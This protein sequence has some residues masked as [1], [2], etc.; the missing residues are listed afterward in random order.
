MNMRDDIPGAVDGPKVQPSAG[1]AGGREPLP[2]A[3]RWTPWTAGRRGGTGVRGRACVWVRVGLWVWIWGFAVTAVAGSWRWSNPWPHGNNIVDLA[4]RGGRYVQVTDHGGIYASTNRLVWERLES[5]TLQDLRGLALLGDRWLVTGAEGTALYSDD[6]VSFHAARLEPP[7]TAWLEGVAASSD[8]AIAVA[9]GDEGTIYRTTDGTN[10]SRVE[11]TPLAAWLSGVAYGG[12]RFVAVGEGGVVASSADGMTW[13][14]ASSPTSAY[15]TRVAYGDGRFLAV[16]DGGEILESTDGLRWR[17]ERQIGLTND[18]LVAAL[19]PGRAVVAGTDALWLRE[20]TGRWL[21]QL[22]DQAIPVPAPEWTYAA[23]VWDGDRWLL[24]GRTGVAVEGVLTN[25]PPLNNV[26]L[27]PRLDDS[28]RG[29]LWAAERIGDTYLAVGERAIVLS[30]LSGAEWRQEIAQTND[31]QTL[32]Y[33]VG[34]SD[35]MALVV[36][37]GGGMVRSAVGYAEVTVTNSLD[38]GGRTHHLVTTNR[39]PLLG[40]EWEAVGGGLTTATLQGVGWNGVEYLVTGENGTLLRSPN[41]RDWTL[42][43]LGTE[44]L[45]SSVAWTG[46]R[47]VASGVSGDRFNL[48]VSEDADRWTALD[49]G[50]TN[51]IYRVRSWPGRVVAVG[52]QGV[53]L[54]SDDGVRW[55]RRESGTTAFLTDV[56]RVGDAYYV[57]GTEGTLRRSLDLVTWTPLSPPTG[58]SILGLASRG[59]QLVAVGA[60]GIILRGVVEPGAEPVAITAFAHRR[61]RVPPVDLLLLEGTPEAGFHLESSEALNGWEIGEAQA[62]DAD[63][64][65]FEAR[66]AATG[67]RFYRTATEDGGR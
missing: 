34:G 57:G 38:A 25:V 17:S 45:V 53:I 5:G 30:S 2:G 47:W 23:A 41:G 65:R 63:G 58:K 61:D 4:Y 19:G 49:S 6:G 24:A 12:G 62:L 1:M 56:R 10:W 14:T 8:P 54:E 26:T 46:S 9:V 50:T 32:Y 20:G 13:E 11:A 22:S 28:V 42:S 31:S 52:Q 18:L 29:S 48:F 64:V 60:E 7:T 15:L 39:V 35:S 55:T 36:G 37:T 33:G 67:S 59:G 21:N 27:W 66:E 51:W 40:L 44:A 3:S 43:R 16:G